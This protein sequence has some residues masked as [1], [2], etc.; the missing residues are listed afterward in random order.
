MAVKVRPLTYEEEQQI[1]RMLESDI[2]EDKKKRLKIVLYSSQ[3]WSPTEINPKVNIHPKTIRHW[4]HT[5]NEEGLSR[6]LHRPEKGGPAKTFD[7]EKREE[8][9]RIGTSKPKNLGEPYTQWSLPKL[10]DYLIKK[11]IVETISHETVRVIL[12]EA[13]ITYQRTKTWMESND[14]D[15]EIKKSHLKLV[16]QSPRGWCVALF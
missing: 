6:L 5:F 12:A 7:K 3:G 13:G 14:P 15:Y 9:V 16:C 4:I 2:S 8:I 11:G 10:R 1:Y